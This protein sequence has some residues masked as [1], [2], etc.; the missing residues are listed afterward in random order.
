MQIKEETNCRVCNGKL[1]VA[2][3]LGNIYP[4]AFLKDDEVV[5]EGGKA[6]LV[7]AECGSCGLV[8]LKHTV[9][10]DSMYRQ[11]WYSSSL[12]KSMVSS[13][14]DI[15]DEIKGRGILE[16][17][18]DVLDIGCNDGT[19]LSLYDNGEH[20]YFKTGFDPALNLTKP[21]NEACDYFINDYFNAEAYE[22]ARPGI[23]RYKAKVITAIAMFYDLPDPNKF[24]A[25]VASVLRDDGIFVIQFTDLV[26]MFQVTAFDNI[27]HEHL[28]YYK[29]SDIEK[30]L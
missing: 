1:K 21:T 10:L 3:D 18:D 11:Y 17:G 26:S 19:L 22:E 9:D 6:P 4:S 30:L 13:L 23:T 16:P 5:D 27:C 12:N 15:V 20:R 7:L 29:V 24:V 2:L 25:D 14:K 8:Q 28:E